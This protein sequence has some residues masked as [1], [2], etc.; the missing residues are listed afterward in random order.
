[1]GGVIGYIPIE[2]LGDLGRFLLV[3]LGMT[4]LATCA[5]DVYTTSF[6]LPTILP[7]LKKVPRVIL[8]ILT[9]AAFTAVAILASGSFISAVTGFHMR[10]GHQ[11][12]DV[13]E[14]RLDG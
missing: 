13:N 9:A 6:N 4:V 8:S 2:R 1:M 12:G 3:V 11:G 5:R 14:S 7:T 10:I